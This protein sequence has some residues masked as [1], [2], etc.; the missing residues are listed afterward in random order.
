MMTPNPLTASTFTAHSNQSENNN[1]FSSD[2]QLPMPSTT[3][4]LHSNNWKV[5]N[6]LAGGDYNS[7]QTTTNEDAHIRSTN[8]P[9]SQSMLPIGGIRVPNP[10]LQNQNGSV[11]NTKP[12]SNNVTGAPGPY[13]TNMN[14]NSDYSTNKPTFSDMNMQFSPG[15]SQPGEKNIVD[16]NANNRRQKRL[17]RNRESARLSRR[18]RKQYLEVLEDRV[19]SLSVQMDEGRIKR[20]AEAV[21][22]TKKLREDRIASIEQE[23]Q[24]LQLDQMN[25]NDSNNQ[26]Q[27]IESESLKLHDRALHTILSRSSNNLRIIAAFQKE[28]QKSYVL[29]PHVR[30]IQW[31]TLQN[32]SFFLGGRAAS[33]RLSAAR[34]GERVRGCMLFESF[35]F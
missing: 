5:Q 8:K 4:T 25:N 23:L 11:I 21:P 9:V 6:P 18:R 14:I 1:N 10:F 2:S 27:L 13:S 22:S 35:H 20:A 12:Q 17:E 3:P 33:E 30:F 7:S 26:K 28:Q 31:L 32:D 16:S 29:P 19:S 34:I 15:T 24:K